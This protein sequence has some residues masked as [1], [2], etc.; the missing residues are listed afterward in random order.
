VVE[1]DSGFGMIWETKKTLFIMP[2]ERIS[3]AGLAIILAPELAVEKDG[4]TATKS[5]FA[6]WKTFFRQ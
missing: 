6:G 1:N 3:G 2:T 5:I 4:T